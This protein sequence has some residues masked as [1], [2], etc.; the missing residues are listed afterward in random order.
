MVNKHKHR[1][2]RNFKTY[3][4]S[5]KD[6]NALIEKKFQK[7]V[8]NKARMKSKKEV[9]HFQE[10]Q[11]SDNESK[12]SISSFAKSVESGEIAASSSE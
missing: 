7:F 11:I 6:I 12:K 5:N 1:K 2:K 4:K 3:G 8:K 9:Q 10:M